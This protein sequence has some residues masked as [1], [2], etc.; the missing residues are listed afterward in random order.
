MFSKIAW[1]RDT[2]WKRVA[3]RGGPTLAAVVLALVLAA[4]PR[5][6]AAPYTYTFTAGSS[7]TWQV[8]NITLCG[9]GPTDHVS[10]SFTYDASDSELSAV[11]VTLTGTGPGDAAGTYTLF[12][13][14]PVGPSH[15]AV[16]DAI[17]FVSLA[18]VNPL[19]GVSD[20]LDPTEDAEQFCLGCGAGGATESFTATGGVTAKAAAPVPEPPGAAILAAALGFFLFGRWALR[21][22][23]QGSA[24]F[25]RGA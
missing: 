22:M 16:F 25:P 9:A 12:A 19:A 14:P 10:G 24:E 21:R 2:T 18:F 11:D 17:G 15:F 5:A 23:P 7:I 3:F 6:S 4:A 13:A 1:K 8:C 20:S